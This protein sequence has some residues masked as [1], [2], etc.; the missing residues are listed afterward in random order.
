MI[1]AGSKGFFLSV[2]FQ[3]HPQQNA[4]YT[5]LRPLQKLLFS[6]FAGAKPSFRTLEK[7]KRYFPEIGKNINVNPIT[8]Y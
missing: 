4:N 1:R 8:G 3:S 7:L 6:F 2:F 5:L